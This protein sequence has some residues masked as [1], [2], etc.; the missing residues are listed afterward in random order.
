MAWRKWVR[1]HIVSCIQLY[2]KFDVPIEIR[3]E[4]R[5]ETSIAKDG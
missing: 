5:T 1:E 2:T 3:K 4:R